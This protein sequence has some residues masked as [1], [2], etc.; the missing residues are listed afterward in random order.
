MRALVATTRALV[1]HA[2][3]TNDRRRVPTVVRCRE[4][5]QAPN[6]PRGPTVRPAVRATRT[7]A[8]PGSRV[9]TV[10]RVTPP[11]RGAL[12]RVAPRLASPLR[13]PRATTTPD[14]RESLAPIAS[15]VTTPRRG[16]RQREDHRH[17]QVRRPSTG[18]PAR[19]RH[20][21]PNS[22]SAK[23]PASALATR[24]GAAWL[25]RVRSTSTARVRN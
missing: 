18:T 6:V 22:E 9:R 11:R 13:G 17:E 25:A 15:Q 8:L 23:R 16:A 4:G 10:K 2:R 21:R 1:S 24:G 14:P 20:P 3:R 5:R 7:V 19:P 12:R